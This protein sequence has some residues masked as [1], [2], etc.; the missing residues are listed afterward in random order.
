MADVAQTNVKKQRCCEGLQQ[1]NEEE[2]KELHFGDP[3]LSFWDHFWGEFE[4]ILA[5]FWV[6]LVWFRH[7]CRATLVR[8]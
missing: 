7:H 5:S 8:F 6:V 2:F 4:V 3:F 1:S